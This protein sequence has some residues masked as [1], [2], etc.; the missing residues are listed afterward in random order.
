MKVKELIINKIENAYD[1][2]DKYKKEV[3]EEFKNGVPDEVKALFIDQIYEDYKNP[4]Q[5]MS[6][7]LK[8]SYQATIADF[9]IYQDIYD[10]ILNGDDVETDLEYIK[11][12]KDEI[13]A[14]D[15][16]KEFADDMKND[17][18]AMRIKYSTTYFNGAD[19]D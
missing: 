8:K 7:A 2:C 14:C 3:N 13:M 10:N 5:A 15:D 9:E 17:Y 4:A 16:I 12:T 11:I 19:Y 18:D 1:L 6:W